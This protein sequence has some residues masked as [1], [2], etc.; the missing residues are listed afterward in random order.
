ML[1][2]ALLTSMGVPCACDLG[3]KLERNVEVASE[4]IL[5]PC[6]ESFSQDADTL[7]KNHQ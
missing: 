3:L 5:H 1:I 6:E 2:S 4:T 7:P